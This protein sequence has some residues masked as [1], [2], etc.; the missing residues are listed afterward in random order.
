V[1]AEEEKESFRIQDRRSFTPEGERRPGT[2]EDRPESAEPPRQETPKEPPRRPAARPRRERLPEIDFATFLLSLGSQALLH[3]GEIPEP[4]T[5]KREKNL[6]LAKQ[7]I[8]LLEILRTKTKGNL[9]REEE[10][11][12][13]SL[14]TDLRM[15]Y[16][17]AAR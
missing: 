7:T 8:D 12:F 15:R 3:L 10:D 4:A 17:A 14:L 1:A 6:D 11:V 2:E 9:T 5:Q 13:Q 16:V